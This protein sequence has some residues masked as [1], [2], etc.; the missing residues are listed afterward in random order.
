MY[1]LISAIVNEKSSTRFVHT[2]DDLEYAK[3][4]MNANVRSCGSAEMTAILISLDHALSATERVELRNAVPL[5]ALM[6][7]ST[8]PA[9]KLHRLSRCHLAS[10]R[11]DAM[12]L[13]VRV[14]ESRGLI[15]V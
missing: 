2:F 3:L 9:G 4:C 13:P 15:A 12:D 1:Y 7:G 10:V 14:G 11:R 8:N 5:D 6:V